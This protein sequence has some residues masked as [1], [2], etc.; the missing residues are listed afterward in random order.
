MILDGKTLADIYQGKI[1]KWND[2]V[3]L[4]VD[5]YVALLSLLM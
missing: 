2:A 3:L 1:S 5:P 4:N